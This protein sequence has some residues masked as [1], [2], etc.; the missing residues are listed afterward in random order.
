MLLTELEYN[1]ITATPDKKKTHRSHTRQ[2]C[3]GRPT[4]ITNTRETVIPDV[5]R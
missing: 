5:L 1:A 3:P 4:Q 2:S